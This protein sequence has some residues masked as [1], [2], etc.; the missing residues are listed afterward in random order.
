[1]RGRLFLQ[2]LTKTKAEEAKLLLLLMSQRTAA[3]EQNDVYGG[4]NKG[5]CFNPFHVSVLGGDEI[6]GY[7]A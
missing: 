2:M 3:H 1:M 4:N 6:V 7:I 5:R